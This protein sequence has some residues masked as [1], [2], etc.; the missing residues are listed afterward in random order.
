MLSV[1][2]PRGLASDLRRLPAAGRV[3]E[4][5]QDVRGGQPGHLDVAR[6]PDPDL[7]D[8][9][10]LAAGRLLLAVLLV[11]RELERALERRQVVGRIDL[12][13]HQR[14]L[15]LRVARREADAPDL[16][17]VLADVPRERVDRAFDDVGRLGPPGPADR[18]RRRLVGHD[19]GELVPVALRVVGAHVDPAPELGDPRREELEVRAHVGQLLH[20]EPQELPLL[21]GRHLDVVDHPATLRRD[22]VAHR[23]VFDPLDRSPGPSGEREAERL[24]RVDVELGAERPTDVGGDDPE[25]VLGDPGGARQGD[26][27]DVRDLRR[28]PQGELAHR[29]HHGGER[30]ARLDRARRDPRSLVPELEPHR[31]GVEHALVA[32]AAVAPMHHGV[33]P[34]LVV[35]ERGAVLGPLLEVEDGGELF[36][37]DGDDLGRVVGLA[38]RLGDDHRHPVTLEP[39]LVLRERPVIRGLDVLGDRPD[40]RQGAGP[41]ARQVGAAPGPDHARHLQRLRDVDLLDARVRERAPDDGEVEH[42]GDRQVVD[43]AALPRQERRVLLAQDRLSDELLGDRHLDPLQAFAPDIVPAASRMDFTMFW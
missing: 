33:G 23:T 7:L 39:R 20:P 37:L 13:P 41:L 26:P 9:P 16:G 42:A 34:E 25:L 43:E 18:V 27:G 11:L 15:R 31:R 12:Q 19:A 10:A 5:A 8:L 36:V 14:R 21:G 17:R 32:A 40:H 29:G 28:G 4:R 35:H 3:A 22:G 38:A 30:A 6:E 2:L 1:T 24:L